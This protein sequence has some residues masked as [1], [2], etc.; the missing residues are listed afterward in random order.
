MTC[1]GGTAGAYRS[2][3]GESKLGGPTRPTLRIAQRRTSEAAAIGPII[4]RPRRQQVTATTAQA[5]DPTTAQV[6]LTGT[7]RPNRLPTATS[8]A[9]GAQIRP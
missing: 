3:S 8:T 2:S 9:I 7:R 6:R 5:T 4:V 1:T